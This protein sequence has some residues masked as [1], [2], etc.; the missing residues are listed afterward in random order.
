MKLEAICVGEAVPRSDFDAEVHSCFGSAVNLRLARSN[1][2]L[3]LV[4]FEQADLPQGIR[5]NTPQG[6]S[7]E[8]LCSGESVTCRDG[9]L[10]CEQTSLTIDLRPAKRWKCNLPA[11]ACNMKNPST[12]AAWQSVAALLDER[13]ILVERGLNTAQIAAARMLR[14]G[15]IDLVA[16]T[17]SHDLAAADVAATLVG[18]GSGL[19]P[20]GDDLLVGYL[21]GLWCTAGENT[22]RS[23]FLSVLGK[24][25][26]RLSRGTNDISRTYL[27]H[28]ARGQVSNR[29][30]TLAKAICQAEPP[31]RI[32]E[33]TE[34]ALQAGHDSGMEGVNG[35]LL[36]LSAWDG[37]PAQ[38]K[39][40]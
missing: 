25:I 8:G 16:T 5:L 32:L 29:L 38:G 13:R 28:A 39:R 35:L 11:L 22:E 2:L 21:A 18:L 3:T 36:G 1:R 10:L 30:A 7:F 12:S 6:F 9:L 40:I 23:R 17:R 27:V 34:A 31:H 24:A 26:I 20:A 19:T 33:A 15:A 14:K 4:T 37:T